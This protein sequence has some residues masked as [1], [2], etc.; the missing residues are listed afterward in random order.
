MNCWRLIPA[1]LCCISTKPELKRLIVNEM[2]HW[3][4]CD[5]MPESSKFD[6][7]SSLM[8]FRKEYRNLLL[9]RLLWND[10]PVRRYIIKILFT[11]MESLHICTPVIGPRLYIQHGFSTIITAKEIGSDC[12]INQQ[13]TIGYSFDAE[14]PV[15]GN[16]VRI[17]AGAK[18]IGNITVGD[19]VIVGANAVAVKDVAENSIVAGVPAKII[20]ENKEHL[21]WTDVEAANL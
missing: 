5:H 2:Y 4:N 7:F 3:K 20:G 13:V 11:E 1:Y 18:V 9:Y 16:G 8:L 15:I 10:A 21:L 19:N 14:P 17:C 12:W 6:V